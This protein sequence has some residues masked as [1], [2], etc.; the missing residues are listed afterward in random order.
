MKNVL[1]T[2]NDNALQNFKVK[3]ARVSLFGRYLKLKFADGERSVIPLS[4]FFT[5]TITKVN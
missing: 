3:S 1:I 4:G 5:A 2:F